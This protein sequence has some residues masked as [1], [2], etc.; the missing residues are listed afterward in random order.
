MTLQARRRRQ[1]AQAQRADAQRRISAAASA[2]LR[3][4]R[5]RELAIDEVMADAGLSRTAFYRYFPDRESL[6]LHLLENA[7]EELHEATAGWLDGDEVDLEGALARETEV[8]ARHA[9]LLRAVAD[10]AATDERI[11]RAYR[12]AVEGF[13]D[14]AEKRIRREQDRGQAQQLDPRLTAEALLWLNERY[15]NIKLGHDDADPAQVAATLAT[16]W[17]RTLALPRGEGRTRHQR[18]RG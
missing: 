8:Y 18:K 2:Q 10:A 13:I 7:A 16:I 3:H 12:A 15:Q 14:S 6:L 4:G 5:F 9:G 17:S 11:E 1:Q